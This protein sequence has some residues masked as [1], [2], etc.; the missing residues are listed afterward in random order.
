MRTAFKL[1]ERLIQ[2][3]KM[4]M[5][6]EFVVSLSANMTFGSLSL[7][8]TRL[9]FEPDILSIRA[10][11]QEIHLSQIERLEL[12][13][14]KL[15]KLIPFYPTLL[16][17]TKEGAKYWFA[18]YRPFS[19]GPRRWA[20]AIRN[21]Q[22]Q[23]IELGPEAEAGGA[24]DS[25]M[26]YYQD[27]GT[28]IGPLSRKEFEYNRQTGQIGPDTLVCAGSGDWKPAS[29]FVSPVDCAAPPSG[30][31]P[32]PAAVDDRF[33]WGIVAVPL[34]GTAIELLTQS[35]LGLLYLGANVLLCLYDERRLRAAGHPAPQTWWAILIPVYLWKRSTLQK[36][37]PILAWAWTAAFVASLILAYFGTQSQLESAACPLV[38]TIIH[39]QLFGSA[40]CK[41]VSITR[42]VGGGFYTATAT[43]DNGHELRITIQNTGDNIEVQIPAQ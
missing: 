16:V 14:T 13:W 42:S 26:F 1:G 8:N 25:A 32:P 20:D 12:G 27:S 18:A 11:T 5:P 43:L 36:K 35:S 9:I 37:K 21:A 17:H 2:T 10:K 6:D 40:E 24:D 30:L 31:T 38:T 39:E 22:A 19:I 23:P 15:I 3:S 29:T 4:G 34:V 41:G 7:T 33:A 28:R